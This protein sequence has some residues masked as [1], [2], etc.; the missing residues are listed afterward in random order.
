MNL[1]EP[2]VPGTV[3]FGDCLEVM[4]RWRPEQVDLIYLDPPFNSKRDYNIIFGGDP[5]PEGRSNEFLAFEDTWHWDER[6]VRRVRD[7]TNRTGRVADA[8]EGLRLVLG[9]SGML[10]Y[11]AYLAERLVEAKRIL[12]PTGSI[13]LHCDP[14]ASHYLKIVMDAVFGAGNFRNEIVWRIGW[15]SGFKTRKRGWIR[16]HDTILY[17]GNGGP[18]TFHKEYLPYPQGYRRRGGGKPTGPGIPLEDTWNCSAPDKLHSIMIES[19]SREKLGYPTQKPVA[20]LQR[21]IRA[22]SNEG[23]LV[24]DPFCGCGTTMVAAIRENRQ[25]AGIDVSPFAV[26]HVIHKR[27]Q[28]IAGGR[29]NIE[30]FP[31]RMKDAA[32]MAANDRF[33][34]EAWAVNL[35]FGLAPNEVKTGDGGVDGRGK[36]LNEI[37]GFAYRGVLAQVKSGTFGMDAVRAFARTLDDPAHRAVAGVFLTLKPNA[38][39]GMRAEAAKLGSFRLVG[40]SREY[41]RFSFWSIEEHFAG[42]TPD[43]P[44]LADP[45]TGRERRT[46][47]ETPTLLE[48]AGDS[49]AADG[50]SSAADS[51]SSA[52][53]GEVR[54]PAAD[55][56]PGRPPRL[57]FTP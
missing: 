34:F 37:E 39:A 32:R 26:Y 21:I 52:A 18:P 48:P 27:L 47:L 42:K 38:T 6:A 51:R 30:G 28:P 35:I 29:V 33:R 4:S 36:F 14:T 5:D 15:V 55:Y 43:L 7:L 25:W 53:D 49:S 44:P 19:F 31:T 11:L 40:S 24:L 9:P 56:D 20:L 2:V 54:E 57:D 10:A 41:P 13:Y 16:N 23:D 8:V 1:I 50:D 46:F 3:Y 12:K 17:Y 22:S 45:L